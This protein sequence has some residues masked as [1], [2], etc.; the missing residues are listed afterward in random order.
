LRKHSLLLKLQ[1]TCVKV[2]CCEGAILEE[3]KNGTKAFD[4]LDLHGEEFFH[5]GICY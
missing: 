3:Q 1:K 5:S 4:V 2:S